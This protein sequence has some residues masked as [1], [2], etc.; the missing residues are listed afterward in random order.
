MHKLN[1]SF[2]LQLLYRD[3]KGRFLNYR[4]M[5][6]W[7]LVEPLIVAFIMFTVFKGLG[8]SDILDNNTYTLYFFSGYLFWV[9]LSS[10]MIESL[11]VYRQ[12]A[13]IFK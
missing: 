1:K 10:T 5:W 2:F 9:F 6:L 3:F 8:R 4:L 12:Y 7:I 11:T 13:S